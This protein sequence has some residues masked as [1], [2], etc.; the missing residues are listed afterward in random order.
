MTQQPWL[1]FTSFKEFAR[2][3][4]Y[5]TIVYFHIF[6]KQPVEAFVL[7]L[8]VLEQHEQL[9]LL[10]YD[11]NIELFKSF[12]PQPKPPCMGAYSKGWVIDFALRPEDIGR[13]VENVRRFY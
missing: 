3:F 5:N 10:K 2:H 6:D 1:R 12:D 11:D 8:G 4:E 7:S 9:V 13:V